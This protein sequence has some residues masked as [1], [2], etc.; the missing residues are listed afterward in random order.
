[1]TALVQAG[2]RESQVFAPHALA[3]VKQQLERISRATRV[4]GS[5]GIGPRSRAWRVPHK[6]TTAP[7]L[8][9]R[10]RY[11]LTWLPAEYSHSL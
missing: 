5:R 8:R 11:L 7:A 6:R 3:A 2:C 4:S 1:M 9:V 10:A